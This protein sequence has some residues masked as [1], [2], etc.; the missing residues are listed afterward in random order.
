VLVT[1][2][3]IGGDHFENNP[4]VTFTVAKG[5]LWKINRLYFYHAGSDVRYAFVSGHGF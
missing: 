3:D 1:A 2:T 5:Q 4:M